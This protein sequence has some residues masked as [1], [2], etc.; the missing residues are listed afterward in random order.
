MR[1][2]FPQNHYK[3]FLIEDHNNSDRE[4]VESHKDK[5]FVEFRKGIDKIISLLS[6]L[7]ELSPTLDKVN[8]NSVETRIQEESLETEHVEIHKIEES[9]VENIESQEDKGRRSKKHDV[10]RPSEVVFPLSDN[11][12]TSIFHASQPTILVFSKFTQLYHV[13]MREEK[14]QVRVKY[15]S[16]RE[17]MKS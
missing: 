17:K 9:L 12:V 2:Q 1:N 13:S 7:K 4:L 5:E 11:D 16:V 3:G 14:V 10:Q 8:D 15:K 6:K